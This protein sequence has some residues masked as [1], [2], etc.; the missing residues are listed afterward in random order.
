MRLALCGNPCCLFVVVVIVV[1]VE[2][3]FTNDYL[4]STNSRQCPLSM[5]ASICSS[6]L[7][8]SLYLQ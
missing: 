5:W 2:F 7:V 6:L 1:Y 3:S 8:S 4:F